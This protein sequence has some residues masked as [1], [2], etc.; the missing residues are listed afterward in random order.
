M[1]Q[2]KIKLR[3]TAVFPGSDYPN[4]SKIRVSS[5]FA[6]KI[7]VASAQADV[8]MVTMADRVIEAGLKN[9]SK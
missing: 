6:K 1:K 3:T 7:K 2:K 9:I 8:D 4:L 5:K